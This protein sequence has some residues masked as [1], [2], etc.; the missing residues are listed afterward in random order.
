MKRLGILIIAMLLCVTASAQNSLSLSS[1]QGHPGDT[2]TLTLSLN[3]SSAVTAMQTF[4][5]LGSQLTYVAGSATLDSRSAGHQLT[6]T[7]LR[8]T[9][10]IYSY[11][12]SLNPYSG[13]SGALLT[14]RVVLRQEPGTYTLPLRSAMLSSA[15]GSSL[16]VQTSAGSVTILAPKISLSHSS[17]D[18]GHCPIR[19]SY[20]RSV[21]V[22]NI[23]NEPLTLS[24]IGLSD[25]TLSA[26]PLTATIAAG[27]QRAVT[28]TYLPVT[29][30]SVTMQGL[31]HSNAMV[32]DSIL[33]ILADPYAVNELRPLAVSGYTDSI[34]TV[35]LRMNNMDSIVGLQTSI[36]LP[37]A[38]TYIDGSFAVDPVRNQGHT[39]TAGL[40]GDTLTLL[41]TNL[42]NRPLR[43]GDGV[44]ASF[45]VRLHGYGS[46]QLQLIG[47][48]L[49]DTAGR[50]VLSA[51]YSQYVS[52]YSPT[53]SCASSTYMGSTPVTDTVEVAFTIN[54]YGNA[55]LMIERVLFVNSIASQHFAVAE[56][57][58][59]MVDNY[60]NATLHIRY[61][62]TDAGN[63][64]TTMQIYNND[65]RRTLQLVSVSGERYEPNALSFGTQGSQVSVELDNYSAVAAIQMD[66]E[67]P[68]R[69]AALES[70]DISTT[71][72]AN[73]HVVSAAQQN[74][75]TMRILLLSMQNTPLT[76][77]SG[78]VLYLDFHPLDSTDYTPYPVRMH[79]VMV[80]NTTGTNVLSSLD[81]ITYIATRLLWDTLYV[82]DTTIVVET[83]FVHDTTTLY[84]HD[85][86]I[87]TEYVHDTTTVTLW[88]TAYVDVYIHDT[89]TMTVWDTAY[90]DVYIHD[91]T[92][93]DNWIYD[94]TYI[95][96]YIHD[97]TYVD[98]YIHDTT[99]VDNYI[100]DTT[101]VDNYIH[102]TT[103][104]DNYIHDTTY[105]DN[106]IY[107]TT[108]VVDTL[109]LT[110]Y[111]T[112]WLH[113]TVY[114]HDTV[115][116]GV[117][118]VDA[119]DTKVYVSHGRVIVEGA[120]GND[121][122]LFDLN[123]RPL[124]TKQDYHEKL[125]F[126]VPAS[127]GYLIK[128]G[129]HT[130]HKVIVVR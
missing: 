130:A 82:H 64:G 33:T 51:V 118:E 74:D 78:P 25:A 83:E 85:T 28:L 50:N 115:S 80:A 57:L 90:V 84:I 17:V 112:I 34:V 59:L 88:D 126:D 44:V 69:F 106:W 27:G 1:S 71:N 89:T 70:T 81:D 63:F 113:D 109:W 120:N 41:V 8:D 98:N 116:V 30:G 73:G 3:N 4:I 75:S 16:S 61:T 45:Q 55:P 39:A 97:T 21:T 53:L 10:R 86:T 110:Q 125:Y 121:V 6:A 66:V 19:S 22:Q 68:H 32:G 46:H 127:G 13:N 72:R 36:R 65:P 23:G 40:Q 43:G 60:Q 11:S 48:A 100:H 107:D 96:V 91:T 87:L 77:N 129:N 12:L 62:G 38:L 47:T 108:I 79:N 26:S 15:T 54:N 76:G 99:Y 124:A 14:F 42:Q 102:D 117:K 56:S 2:L 119:I 29:A 24:G 94:T 105:V 35:Q 37:E 95:N 111:D 31:F 128:I 9:L 103:Y 58:P 101:Y 49:A 20:T 93:V 92:Y 5:P 18:F 67:Y 122:T 114:I 52:I 7:V 123:G 104:V